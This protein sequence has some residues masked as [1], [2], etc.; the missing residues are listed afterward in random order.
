MGSG[1]LKKGRR[2]EAKQL[3]RDRLRSLLM[4]VRVLL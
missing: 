1:A 4:H 2:R 3:G